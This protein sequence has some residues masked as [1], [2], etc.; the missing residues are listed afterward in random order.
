MFFARKNR[1]TNVPVENP[2]DPGSIEWYMREWA[3][4]AAVE[5]YSWWIYEQFANE[6]TARKIW[7]YEAM[8]NAL[9]EEIFGKKAY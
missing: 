7:E 6:E 5:R 8:M 2:V 3:K 9:V 1:K 4:D